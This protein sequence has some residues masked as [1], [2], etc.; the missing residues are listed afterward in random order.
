MDNYEKHVQNLE[1]NN[2]R[3][4]ENDGGVILIQASNVTPRP[5][6][7]IMKDWL[8]KN[9][10]H[11]LG[12]AGGTGK[13]TLALSIASIIT[14]GGVFPNGERCFTSGNI[15]IWSGEDTIERT[16]VPRLIASGADLTKCFFITE[17]SE[18]GGKKRAFNP[19]TDF[20]KLDEEII[21]I[22]NVELLIVDPIV[23]SIKG[24][25]NDANDVRKGLQPFLDF[26]DKHGCAVIGITHFGKGTQGRDITERIIGSQAFTAV[27]RVVWA[28][29][30]NE[31]GDRVL[32]HPKNNLGSVKGGF[33]YE[34][35]MTELPDEI[36]ASKIVWKGKIDG[37]AKDILGQYETMPEE[38][39]GDQNAL[40]E[41][42]AFLN[43]I[44]QFEDLPAKEVYKQA[45]DAGISKATIKRAKKLLGI[46]AIK[47][48]MNGGWSW[49]LFP[50][51]AQVF[52]KDLKQNDE[53]LQ[54][55]V[56][57]FE[58]NMQDH[59]HD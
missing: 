8:A 11:I 40:R 10:F 14:N 2:P 3:G 25:M 34:C 18:Y 4:V 42:M 13:T 37:N 1:I 35:E 28:T 59:F 36:E 43:Q 56:S 57:I 26:T 52:S 53:P 27:A 47:N 22:C 32:V 24:R 23:T 51:V 31:S 45:E 39:Q 33:L 6:K 41:A 48:G 49:S 58:K 7:W 55:K 16:L 44:L 15:L 20:P 9:E 54:N 30:S 17:Y 19:I 38:S 21:K 50:E 46:K 29:A 5:I 12:G